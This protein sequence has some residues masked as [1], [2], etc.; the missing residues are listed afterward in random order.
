MESE[1][2]VLDGVEEVV[3]QVIG[4]AVGQPLPIVALAEAQHAAH[5][6]DAHNNAARQEEVRCLPL[7]K[8]VVDGP[9]DNLGHDEI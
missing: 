9:G 1:G 6:G 4:H 2:L 8:A 7:V 5:Q 3:A